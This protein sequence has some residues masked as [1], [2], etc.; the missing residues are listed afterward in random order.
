MFDRRNQDDFVIYCFQKIFKRQQNDITIYKTRT[1]QPDNVIDTGRIIETA[2]FV[3]QK[4]SKIIQFPAQ[5]EKNNK[6]ICVQGKFKKVWQG[7]C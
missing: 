3:G 1:I 5:I 7:N 6:I 4:W 2:M